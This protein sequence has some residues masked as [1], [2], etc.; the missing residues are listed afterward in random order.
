MKIVIL[1]W[2]FV[3]ILTLLFVNVSRI[4]AQSYRTAVGFR[5]GKQVTFSVSQRIAKKSTL[6]LYHES[7]LFSNQMFTGL[8][9]KKHFPLIT[10]RLNIFLGVGP[11]HRFQAIQDASDVAVSD[12]HT[13]GLIGL[14][15]LDFTIGR[16]NIGYDIMP[17]VQMVGTDKSRLFSSYSGITLRYVVWK[18]PSKVKSWFRKK[19]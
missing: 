13:G 14:A 19:S 3:L 17:V 2:K 8:A 1:P 12:Y 15:G 18:Q 5:L 4:S 16:F 10:K 11:Y 7:S 9:Y 6:D